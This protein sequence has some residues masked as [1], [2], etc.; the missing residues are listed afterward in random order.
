M[1]FEWQST[2][3]SISTIAKL[4]CAITIADMLWRKVVDT[5]LP[6]PLTLAKSL[7]SSLLRADVKKAWPEA[8]M[9]KGVLLVN[10]FLSFSVMN[11][12]RRV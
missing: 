10:F 7:Q 2:Y 1:A 9:K 4:G 6:K 3:S 12:N 11:L 5:T 8:S